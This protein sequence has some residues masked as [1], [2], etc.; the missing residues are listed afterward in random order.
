MSKQTEDMK[1]FDAR[2]QA[3]RAAKTAREYRREPEKAMHLANEAASKAERNKDS[4]GKIR[5][6]LATLVRLVR[7]WSQKEYAQVPW[8]TIAIAL[9]AVIYFVNPFD[10]VPTSFR[11]SVTSTTH[12]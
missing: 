11:A 12:W 6:E 4:L 1:D 10:A 7:A 2:A 8:T 5:G 3:N 9:G